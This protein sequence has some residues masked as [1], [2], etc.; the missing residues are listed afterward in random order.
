MTAEIVIMNKS[1][2]AIASDSAVTI[3]G[4][5][6]TTAEKIFTL[7]KYAPVG[8]MIFDNASFMEVSW[9]V[10]IKKYRKELDKKVFNKLEEY[11]SDFINFLNREHSLFPILEQNRIAKNYITENIDSWLLSIKK[12]IENVIREKGE[13][14]EKQIE[15]LIDGYI[16]KTYK[17][18]DNMPTLKIFQKDYKKKLKEKYK[19]F[20]SAEIDEAFQ[21]LPLN[22]PTKN[23]IIELNILIFLKEVFHID[24]HSGVVIT[25]Y[26]EKEDFPSCMFIEFEVKILNQVKYFIN[27]HRKIDDKSIS[28]VMPFAQRE[29]IHQFME[30][31]HPKYQSVMEEVL[32]E[33]CNSYPKIISDYLESMGKLNK[34]DVKDLLDKSKKYGNKILKNA[35]EELLDVRQHFFIHP[36]TTAVATLTK[37]ELAELAESL[38]YLTSLKKKMTTEPQTVGGPTDVALISKSDGFIWIKRKHYFNPELNPHFFQKY[39]KDGITIHNMKEKPK[40]NK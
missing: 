20:I 39:Y 22:K 12:V 14:N 19:D 35:K 37:S 6:S 18:F 9:E 25:G 1:T 4:K 26:G 33:V 3:G 31:V 36:T 13:I 32:S 40:I 24:Y 11:V 17:K 38:V 34:N 28:W 2:I 27:K 10:I 30:G 5:V 8:I 7:S 15:D 21:K 23:K 16:L 29:M